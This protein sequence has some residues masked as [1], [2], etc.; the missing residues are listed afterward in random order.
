MSGKRLLFALIASAMAVPGATRLT[1]A[2]FGTTREGTPV[3]LYTLKNGNGVEATITNYGGRIVSLKV[4]DKRGA[5]GDVIAGFDSLE[6]FLNTNP[7]FGAL[8][9]RYA[10]RIGHA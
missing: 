9:G 6:G 1:S 10:N 2:D 3:R 4:P 7:Y 5:M 8:V